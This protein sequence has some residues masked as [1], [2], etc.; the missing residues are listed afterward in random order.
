MPPTILQELRVVPQRLQRLPLHLAP[1]LRPPLPGQ[2][3][4]GRAAARA[5]QQT[6]EPGRHKGQVHQHVGQ[7]N[8]TTYAERKT[9]D[10]SGLARTWLG[11]HCLRV[12]GTHAATFL[13]LFVESPPPPPGTSRPWWS[14]ALPARRPPCRRP[15]RATCSPARGCPPSGEGGNIGF[16]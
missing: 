16:S 3:G 4:S 15:R 8:M 14:A 11:H 7:V 12:C 9:T 13:F 2:L 1:R 5:T 10:T 6:V